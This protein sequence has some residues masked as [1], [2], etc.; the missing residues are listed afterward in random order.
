MTDDHMELTGVIPDL[1]PDDFDRTGSTH[2]RE[3]LARGEIETGKEISALRR[4]I[5]LSQPQFASALGISVHTLRNWEQARR[6]P[7]GPAR[8]LLRIAARHPSVVHENLIAST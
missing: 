4:F 2:L 5:G 7:E 8:A 6:S 3:R 1:T